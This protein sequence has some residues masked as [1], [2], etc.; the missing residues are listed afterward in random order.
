MKTGI[1]LVNLGTPDS[2]SIRD[3]RK[4]LTEFLNDP[5]IIDIPL[6]KRFFL[7]NF[8]I[9]PFRAP[10]TTRLY[11][12]IWTD[13]GSPILMHG[14]DVKEKLQE[15]LGEDYIVELGMRYQHPDLKS[16]LEKLKAENVSK[17]IVVP[18][19]PQYASSTTGTTIE[20]IKKAFKW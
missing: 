6:L 13:K 20:K 5:Y 1:L 19:Y 10:K 9:V 3:V 18:M 16:A 2:P 7:V 12:E 4:Y 14:I 8:I 15:E 17:I 11:K